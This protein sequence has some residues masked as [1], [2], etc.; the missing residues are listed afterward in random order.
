MQHYHN[1]RVTYHGATNTR[2][3]RIT[4]KSWRFN[5]SVTLPYSYEGS[6]IEQA[7]QWLT[8]KGFNLVGYSDLEGTPY[9]LIFTDTFEPL[10]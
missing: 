4:L 7:A 1:I 9:Y 8:N 6:T 2:G 5:Q 10:K 3:S